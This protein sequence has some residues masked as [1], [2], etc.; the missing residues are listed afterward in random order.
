MKFDGDDLHHRE[1]L[2]QISSKNSTE[3][4]DKWPGL[5]GAV[6]KLISHK[7]WTIYIHTHRTPCQM[8]YQ[9]FKKYLKFQLHN[10]LSSYIFLE[11][12]NNGFLLYIYIYIYL[13]RDK[14]SSELRCQSWIASLRKNIKVR[15]WW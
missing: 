9:L 12:K 10:F 14:G 1:N 11:F 8:H 5:Y 7:N 15:D 4:W 13:K 3:K 2:H 6:R